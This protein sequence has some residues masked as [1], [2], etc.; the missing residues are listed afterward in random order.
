MFR[1]L[2][3]LTRLL[4]LVALFA[5]CDHPE[6]PESPY[7]R[8]E[9]LPVANI[10]ETGV[11]LRGSITKGGSQSITDHGFVWGTSENISLNTADCGSHVHTQV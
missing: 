2:C 4:I 11:T 8:I 5:G 3:A 9:T 7:P 1:L 6:F 10:S